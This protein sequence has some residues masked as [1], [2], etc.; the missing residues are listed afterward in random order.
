MDSCTA[1]EKGWLPSLGSP[2]T[3]PVIEREELLQGAFLT[4]NVKLS[5]VKSIGIITARMSGFTYFGLC[6]QA[7]ECGMC[8]MTDLY[9]VF[10]SYLVKFID[11]FFF[12]YVLNDYRHIIVRAAWW[13]LASLKHDHIRKQNRSLLNDFLECKSLWEGSKWFWQHR[14]PPVAGSCDG[15]TTDGSWPT[16]QFPWYCPIPNAP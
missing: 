15:Q 8:N 14:E 1:W 4:S 6:C 11:A 13:Y 16:C 7:S 5:C 3:A 10:L 2:E 12:R 9:M